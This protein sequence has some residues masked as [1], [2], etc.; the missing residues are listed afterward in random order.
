MECTGQTGL[1]EAFGRGEFCVCGELAW[2][3]NPRTCA[4]CLLGRNVVVGTEDKGENPK[5]PNPNR[6]P[7][8]DLV[9]GS[10]GPG[11]DQR[12][13]GSEAGMFSEGAREQIEEWAKRLRLQGDFSYQACEEFLEAFPPG[14]MKGK[15]EMAAGGKGEYQTFGAFS[16]GGQY[17]TTVVCDQLPETTKYLNTFI[18]SKAQEHDHWSSFTI[19]RNQKLP[20]HRDVHNHPQELSLICGFGLYQKGALWVEDPD[21][22]SEDRVIQVLPDGRR[23]AGREL[24]IHHQFQYFN[25][26]AWHGPQPWSGNR[27][28][29]TAF[30]SRGVNHLTEKQRDALRGRGFKLP[31]LRPEAFSVTPK[32]EAYP[33][34]EVPM[35]PQGNREE[36]EK[37]EKIRKQLYLLHSATGH[38]S[39]KHLIDALRRRGASKEVM[40]EAEQFT[41][42]V[43]AERSKVSSR[44]VASLEPLPPKWATVSAD[45][46]HLQHPVTKDHAQFLLILDEGSRFRTARILTK[47]PKQAPNA[48]SCLQ[49]FQ[50]GWCQIFGHPRTLRLDPAGAFRSHLVEEYCDK[51]NIFLDIIP[52][53][54]HWKIGACENGIKGIKEVVAK[55]CACEPDIS[56]EEALSTAVRTFNQRDMVRGFSPVQH[57]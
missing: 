27:I 5:D 46:G 43:C 40:E 18:R 48:L 39:K 16:H 55:L 2:P 14:S 53:E 13:C 23:V 22:I 50:E 26:K 9:Q 30:T 4:S 8:E 41:C 38:C 1:P 12:S 42:S 25:G 45:V 47:G 17:G 24:N 10:S 49:Y 28:T 32:P 3:G 51:H 19:N 54:A 15:R 20:I 11:G 44:H 29:L 6:G 35:R 56:L 33:A 57:A 31:R 36:R 37:R 34:D 21:V 52:G 7:R